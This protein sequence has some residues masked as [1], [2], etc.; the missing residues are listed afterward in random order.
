M[1]KLTP[2]FSALLLCAGA[3]PARAAAIDAAMVLL[4]VSSRAYDC[5]AGDTCIETTV[6]AVNMADI[7]ELDPKGKKLTA[8]DVERRGQASEITAEQEAGGR[9]VVSGADGGRGW[10]L[11]VDE[12]SGDSVL[13]VSDTGIAIVVYGECTPK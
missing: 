4:C 2:L 3:P 1:R 5:S 12:T 10:K 9:L 7:L 8:L 13:T 11:A 6:E